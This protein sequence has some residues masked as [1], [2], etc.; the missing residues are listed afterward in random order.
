M[1]NAQDGISLIQTA[2]GA[3]NETHA[4]LQRMRELATQAATDTNTLTDRKE[5][6]KEINQLL[7]E[8]DRIGN[9]TEF[10]TQKLLDGSY[11]GKK[12]HI[13]AN[14]DQGMDINI[15]NMKTTV[16]GVAGTGGS[17]TPATGDL[18]GVSFTAVT[19]GTVG[20]S[21]EIEFVDPGSND[22]S[23]SVSVSGNKITVNLATDSSG[24]IT[25]TASQIVSA[26]NGDGDASAGNR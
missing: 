12:F 16:L 23:L 22:A 9:N 7:D 5:I 10:N 20:N 11:S 3:L 4:I 21:I 14:E 19:A 6:Q 8:I 15:S 17:A 1:R 26:I 24:N 13:G 25:S 2:E 18:E